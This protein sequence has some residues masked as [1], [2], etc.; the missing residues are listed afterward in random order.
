MTKAAWRGIRFLVPGFDTAISGIGGGLTIEDRGALDTTADRAAVRQAL[1]LLFLTR[2]G[3]RV[4]RPD[5]G[6]ELYKLVF[7]PNDD[8]TAGLAMHYVRQAVA[9]WEPR[10]DHVRVD[11]TRNPDDPTRLDIGLEYRVRSTGEEDRLSVQLDLQG[12]GV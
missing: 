6:C 9:R 11:A 4:M 8:T 2:P 3:E 1:L 10:V 12:G 7:W 5:Y